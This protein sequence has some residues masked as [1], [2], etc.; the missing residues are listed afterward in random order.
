LFSMRGLAGTS[1]PESRGAL[2][3]GLC[4]TTAPAGIGITLIALAL[5]TLAGAAAIC[6]SEWDGVDMLSS[7]VMPLSRRAW[8]HGPCFAS[9]IVSCCIT[10]LRM[11]FTCTFL[12]LSAASSGASPI[13]MA[14]FLS[15]NRRLSRMISFNQC[16]RFSEAGHP[17]LEVFLKRC[18]FLEFILGLEVL[19]INLLQGLRWG[20]AIGPRYPCYFSTADGLSGHSCHT[21][22]WR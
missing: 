13:I 14:G 16:A 12:F 20:T 5:G 6:P 10:T 8:F 4:S 11:S 9:T 17:L 3:F 21:S 2:E 18:S 19:L 1:V 7:R 15:S 22:H